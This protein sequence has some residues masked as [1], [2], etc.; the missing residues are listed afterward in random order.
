MWEGDL[1]VIDELV[2][3]DFVNHNPLVPDT[4]PGPD[5][6]KR[7]VSLLRTAFPDIEFGMEDVVA[8]GDK[9]VL[10]AVGHG[11]HDG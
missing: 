4:P 5:G 11:T 9:V 3:D 10:R 1:S 8:E 6:F 2:A 7:N